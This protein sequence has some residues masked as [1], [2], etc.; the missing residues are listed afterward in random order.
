LG[1]GG[2]GCG[3]AFVSP[4]GRGGGPFFWV[5]CAPPRGPGGE[6]PGGGG[7]GEG[8]LQLLSEGHRYIRFAH[9][10]ERGGGY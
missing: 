9:V 4:F 6:I 3:G 7:G 2:G 1:G 8:A 10:H 5:S